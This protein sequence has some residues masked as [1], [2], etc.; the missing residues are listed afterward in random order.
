MYIISLHNSFK[1]FSGQKGASEDDKKIL[2]SG[3]LKTASLLKKKNGNDISEV[4]GT[5]AAG[6]ELRN[7]FLMYRWY[8][9][10]LFRSI[11]ESSNTK[12]GR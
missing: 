9:W 12:E 8:N 1:T 3:M 7:K 11:W 10:R 4:P 2:E 6:K 5:G